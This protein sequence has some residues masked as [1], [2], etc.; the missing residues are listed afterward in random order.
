MTSPLSGAPRG[1]AIAALTAGAL[2]ALLAALTR[3][4]PHLILPALALA[5]IAIVT[6]IIG[7]TQS[8]RR[9][10][11]GL[12][13]SIAGLAFTLVP[14]GMLVLFILIAIGALRR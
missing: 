7:I 6:G 11:R 1:S 12:A 2:G 14:L 9:S 5:A 13:F 10:S 4:G 8:V 3:F